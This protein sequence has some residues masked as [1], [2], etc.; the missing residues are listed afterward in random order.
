MTVT[1]AGRRR[2]RRATEPE[3][4]FAPL[5]TKLL[6]PPARP[7]VVARRSLAKRLRASAETP[8]VCVAAPA[9][10]GKTTLLAQWG[11]S[12]PR[13]FA[14]VSLDGTDNDPVEL[15][16]YVALALNRLEPLGGAVFAALSVR[17]PAIETVV[18]P[19]LG[20]AISSLKQPFVLVLDDVH[21]L[22]S[23]RS[24]GAIAVLLG[25]LPAGSQLVLAWRSEPAFP[26]ARL[27]AERALLEL[28]A[29]DLAFDSKAADALLRAAGVRLS[30]DDLC[31][32]TERTE[33]WPAGL[34]LAALSLKSQGT[35]VAPV[36]GFAGDDRAVA[37]YFG[38]QVLA[39]LPRG[40][41]LFLIRTS[42]L[43]RLSGPLCDALL[44]SNG[45]AA[46]LRKLE[47]SN[48]FLLPLDRRRAWYRY[49]TLFAEM[50]RRRLH[51][52]EPE[53][54]LELHRRAADWY[55][56]HGD[57]SEAIHH[58]L[59]ADDTTFA[60]D[61]VWAHVNSYRGRGRCA[62]LERWLAAFS[63]EQVAAYPPLALAA[64]WTALGSDGEAVERW[65]TAA[66][67]GSHEG[68]LSDGS[69]SLE[70]AVAVLGAVIAGE[71][72][73]RMAEDAAR[74]R[75]L[76]SGDSPWHANV[77]Y[78]EGVAA[79][80]TGDAARA[81]VLLQEGERIAA[82]HGLASVR[83]LCL[84]QLALLATYEESWEAAASLVALA[85]AD[86][87][88]LGMEEHG[89]MAPVFTA[90][91]LVLAHQQRSEEA[92][93]ELIHARR[94][95]AG[96][97]QVSPWFAVEARLI[98]ARASLLLADAVAAR[99]LVAEARRL[100]RSAPGLQPLRATVTELTKLVESAPAG[101][102]TGPSALTTA[103]VRLLHILPTH[104]TFREIGER[105]HLS[106]NTV[107]TQA[108]SI[109]RK[110]SVSRRS[111][112]VERAMELGLL[113]V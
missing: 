107:K 17:N 80:L 12:D 89:A 13:P 53:L 48:L 27:R 99:N 32:I 43:E 23:D 54:E 30:S 109:Y 110:L 19:Q 49:H 92:G 96:Q 79:R 85:Q 38:E 111:E 28:G 21:A 94:L 63:D 6:A 66:A 68:P 97:T 42:V 4:R 105:M 72:V 77:C 51:D 37:D 62:T 25:H 7:G 18:L 1:T 8:L 93:R 31:L 67:N 15:L 103:E 57:P 39:R 76:E 35:V 11:E 60:G 46:K 58:A 88:G 69:A 91:A 47:R 20:K 50:L 106:R 81:R 104:L 9:G 90:A 71:G 64:A 14:W 112:A 108:V 52:E 16:T 22:S 83:A 45:S 34:Y 87:D 102:L 2:R 10:Y 84:A 26:L 100:M 86:V 75:A 59:Q 41:A 95:L 65:A 73:A 5:E 24:L 44:E 70:S 55:A 78:A 98:L 74:A 101:G 82:V 33:G 40:V 113:E 3:A 61:V 36:A 56:A 29:D